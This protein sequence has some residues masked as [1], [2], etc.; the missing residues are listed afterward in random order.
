MLDIPRTRIA[1]IADLLQSNGWRFVLKEMLLRRRRAILVEK[2]L[3]EIQ[4]RPDILAGSKS[5][6]R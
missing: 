3:F 2:N 5:E 6:A 1:Q 4:G